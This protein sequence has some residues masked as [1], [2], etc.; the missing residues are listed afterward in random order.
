MLLKQ[1]DLHCS[2]VICSILIVVIAL[3]ENRVA[4]MFDAR[5]HRR[6]RV[7]HGIGRILVAA[8]NS[9]N[10]LQLLET[11]NFSRGKRIAEATPVRIF[12]SQEPCTG[13]DEN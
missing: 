2:R 9:S 10:L 3:A 12:K 11:H 8:Y 7:G 4:V 5:R 13:P 1:H 6:I